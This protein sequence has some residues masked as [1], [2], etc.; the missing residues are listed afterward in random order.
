M[1]KWEHR[2]RSKSPCSEEQRDLQR[3]DIS[4][5]LSFSILI[6]IY[7]PRSPHFLLQLDIIVRLLFGLVHLSLKVGTAPRLDV[8]SSGAWCLV[9]G[10]TRSLRELKSQVKGDIY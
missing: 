9:P 6:S 1:L 4:N 8:F 10:N 7:F 5:H 2:T 3:W